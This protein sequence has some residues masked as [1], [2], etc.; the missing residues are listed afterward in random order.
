MYLDIA[1]QLVQTKWE[2]PMRLAASTAR[3]ALQAGLQRCFAA[4]CGAAAIA[5]VR[6]Y[7]ENQWR[8]LTRP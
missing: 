1:P 3:Q 8:A 6:Q 5:I 4:S 2:R 7:I